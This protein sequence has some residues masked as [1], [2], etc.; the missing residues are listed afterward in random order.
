MKG[1][2]PVQNGLWGDV[3]SARTDGEPGGLGDWET[4]EAH[5]MESLGEVLSLV[6]T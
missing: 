2:D 3:R 4:T 5:L 1:Y 6:G